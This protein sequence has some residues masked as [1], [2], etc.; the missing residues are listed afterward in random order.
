MFFSQRNGV[1]HTNPYFRSRSTMLYASTLYPSRGQRVSDSFL[2]WPK[3]GP[4][5]FCIFSILGHRK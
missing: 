1:N 5:F 4:S 2:F 3:F